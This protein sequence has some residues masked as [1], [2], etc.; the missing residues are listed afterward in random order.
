MEL[1]AVV[2][3]VTE[4]FYIPWDTDMFMRGLNNLRT[5]I[6]GAFNVGF[7][8]FLGLA[9]LFVVKAIIEHFLG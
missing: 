8:V 5:S 4:N 6:G 1:M 2:E 3:L 7:W 9:G